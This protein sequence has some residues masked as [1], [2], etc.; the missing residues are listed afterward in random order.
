M[1]VYTWCYIEYNSMSLHVDG[2]TV[3]HYIDSFGT[4]TVVTS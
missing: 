2:H 3:A 1:K 4:V